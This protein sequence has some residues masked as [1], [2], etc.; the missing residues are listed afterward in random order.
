MKLVDFSIDIYF[1]LQYFCFSFYSKNRQELEKVKRKLEADL[2]DHRD[3][4]NEKRAQVEE[5]QSQLARREEELQ[6]ALQK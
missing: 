5:V 1:Y 2:A 3:Q 4:L 6:A